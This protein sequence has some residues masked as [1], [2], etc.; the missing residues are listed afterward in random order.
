M[1]RER[2]NNEAGGKGKS[3]VARHVGKGWTPRLEW[4][5]VVAGFRRRRGESSPLVFLLG[6]RRYS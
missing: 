2:R 4:L 5:V 3:I 6:V 1:A